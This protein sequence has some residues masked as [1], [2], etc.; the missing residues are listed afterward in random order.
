MTVNISCC[1]F[2]KY[3][4]LSLLFFCV[5]LY[6][7]MKQAAV[8]TVY[9][10]AAASCSRGVREKTFLLSFSGSFDFSF[11]SF[12]HPHGFFLKAHCGFFVIATAGFVLG[13]G[14]ERSCLQYPTETLCG[15]SA[16]QIFH[17]VCFFSH[18]IDAVPP[19]QPQKCHNAL[20]ACV[21]EHRQDNV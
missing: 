5:K 11:C 6:L 2:I 17:P 8:K 7:E 3:S 12:F 16:G 19:S 21:G 10:N 15:S 1:L 13:E 4:L 18:N 14:A 9:V 20:F